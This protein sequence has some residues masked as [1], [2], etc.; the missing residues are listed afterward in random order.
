MKGLCEYVMEASTAWNNG[1]WTG[2]ESTAYA[3][4]VEATI[5]QDQLSKEEVFQPLS[6]ESPDSKWQWFKVTSL[7]V[8]STP[9]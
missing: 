8:D 4:Y 6:P 9:H 5:H 1:S 3:D 7:R 2:G